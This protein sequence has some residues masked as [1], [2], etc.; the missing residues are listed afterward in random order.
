MIAKRS[1]APQPTSSEAAR[2]YAVYGL[3]LASDIPL[4]SLVEVEEGTAAIA[5]ARQ[6]PAFVRARVPVVPEGPE[7]W[8]RHAVL[9]D[10]SVY[11]RVEAAFEAIVAADGRRADCVRLEGDSRVF[12]AQLL[13]FVLSTAL[14]LQGEEPLHATVLDLGASAV[15][16]LGPSGAGK[17]TLAA[18]LIAGGADLVTD[19]MLRLVFE[20]GRAL[21][22][23][24][25]YRLKLF[26]EPA[27]RLLAGAALFGAFDRLGEKRLVRPRMASP[28]MR[29]HPLS[30]LFWLGDMPTSER[31]EGGRLEGTALARALIASAMNT[32]YLTP[33]RLARQ[34]RFAERVG[35]ELPMFRLAY[36]RRFELLDEVAVKVRQLSCEHVRRRSQH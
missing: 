9:D 32:R 8:I 21:A 4:P 10:G 19:D 16:L 29:P 23:P 27:R 20:D 5:L 2:R 1:A 30:A 25:P 26:E 24:G 6:S 34:L 15:A 12:E 36:P 28:P 17:S 35:R 13:N 14:T 22:H 3:T 31:L 11:V 33:E 18:C 7:D